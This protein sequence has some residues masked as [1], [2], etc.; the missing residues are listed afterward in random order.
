MGQLN[1]LPDGVLC[2]TGQ[3]LSHRA[4]SYRTASR[5][6]QAVASLLLLQADIITSADRVD[7]WPP[8]VRY[9]FA[10]T[11]IQVKAG[12]QVGAIMEGHNDLAIQLLTVLARQ[13][14]HGADGLKASVDKCVA[15]MVCGVV[16]V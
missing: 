3:H 6:Q 16:H 7:E 12:Q 9:A 13:Y 10:L 11:D 2:G 8:S 4:H 1:V 5:L 15:R 14:H